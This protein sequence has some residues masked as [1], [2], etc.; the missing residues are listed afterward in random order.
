MNFNATSKSNCTSV[1]KFF[2]LTSIYNIRC[3][4]LIAFLFFPNQITLTQQPSP[5]HHKK[6]LSLHPNSYAF[7][8]QKQCN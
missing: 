7:T 4:T 1:G 3:K 6:A 8:T 5:P 2:Y